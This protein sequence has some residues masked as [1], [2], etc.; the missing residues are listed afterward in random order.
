M[1]LLR[2]PNGAVVDVPDEQVGN[3]VGYEPVEG[4]RAASAIASP[5]SPDRGVLGGVNAAATG[6]LSGITLGGSDYLLK[7]VLNQGQGERLSAEREAHPIAGGAGQIIGAIAPTLAAPGSLLGLSPA[8]LVG[9]ATADTVAAGRALGGAEGVA[10]QLVA[11]GIEG[12]VQNAGMYLSDTALSDRELSAEGLAASLGPGFAFGVA[13]GAAALGIEQGTIAARRLFSRAAGTDKAAMEAEAAWKQTQQA[14]FDANDA[15]AD[16]ARAK[17]AEARAMREQAQIAKQRAKLSVV[18]TE[19][20][21]PQ[22]DATHQAAAVER[23]QVR[24]A[25]KA[26]YEAAPVAPQTPAAPAIDQQTREGLYGLGLTDADIAA[27]KPAELADAIRI[28]HESNAEMAMGHITAG[29]P[30]RVPLN[31]AAEQ[32]LSTAVAEHDAARAE[33]EDVLRR[34][35]PSSIELTTG[36]ATGPAVPIAEW[37]PPGMRGYDPGNVKAPGPPSVVEAATGDVT[38]V[39]KKKLAEG[40]PAEFTVAGKRSALGTPGPHEPPQVSVTSELSPMPVGTS[41]TKPA[42]VD[43]GS[44]AT[45]EDVAAAQKGIGDRL[46]AL[47]AEGKSGSKEYVEL[48][49]QWDEAVA[50]RQELASGKARARIESGA[51]AP[52]TLNEDEFEAFSKSWQKSLAPEAERA[53]QVYTSNGAYS[54]V[55]GPLRAGK[56][57]SGIGRPELRDAVPVLDAGIASAPAPRDMMVHRGVSGTRSTREWNDVAVGDSIVDR[58]F[59][60]TS[61]MPHVGNSYA[62]GMGV[63]K[64]VEL[65]ILVP[66]GYPAA[67]VPSE[68][69]GAEREILLPRNTKYTVTRVVDHDG[70]R[71]VFVT[72]GPAAEGEASVVAAV[73]RRNAKTI[74]ELTLPELEQR[75]MRLDDRRRELDRTEE[76]RKSAEIKSINDDLDRIDQRRKDIKSGKVQEPKPDEPPKAP[77]A[78]APT[79]TPTGLESLLDMQRRAGQATHGAATNTL[80]GQLRSMES[81]LGAG[82]DLKAMGAPARAEYAAAKAEK[83]AAASEHFR[84][85]ANAKNYAGSAM[86][87]EERAAFFA[88]LTRPKTRDAYV[89]QNIGR[90]MKEE[91]SHAK[92]LA[93]V[94]REWAEMAGPT[95]PDAAPATEPQSFASRFDQAFH[96]IDA[97]TGG[98]NYVKVSDLRKALPDMPREEFDKALYDLRKKKIWSMDSPDGR[99]V[100]LS[101]EEIEAGIPEGPIGNSGLQNRLTYVQR[102]EKYEPVAA[103]AAKQSAP[104]VEHI[105]AG[106]TKLKLTT[107]TK[108]LVPGGKPRTTVTLTRTLSDGEEVTAGTAEFLHTSEGLY[109]EH[110]NIEPALQKQG[111]GTKIYDS[112]EKSTGQKI[113]QSE[114]QTPA[115]KAFRAAR[116]E[117]HPLS[118]AKLEQAHEAAVERAAAATSPAEQV[119]AEREVHAIEQQLTAVGKRPG[120]VEDVAAVA[121]AATKYE[122][123]SARLAEALGPDAPPAAQE[124]A[125]A[126]RA[127]EDAA[128]RKTMDRTTRAIDDHVDSQGRPRTVVSESR[129]RS[130]AKMAAGSASTAVPVTPAPAASSRPSWED[131]EAKYGKYAGQPA[132]PPTAAQALEAAKAA[133]GT[134][135]TALQRARLAEM[136]AKAG[137]RQATDT[138]AAAR[139]SR[140]QAPTAAP[141]STSSLGSVL[142][143]IGVAGELGVPGIPHPHDIPVIGPFLGAYLKFRAIKAAAGRFVGRI[144]ATGDARAAALVAKT[145]DKIAHAVDRTLGLVAETAPKVR[146]GMVATTTVLGHRLIDDGE[147]DAPKN[148]NAQQ[149]AAVRI[150]EIANAVSRPDLVTQLVRKEM[151][152]VAD[153]DLIA[154][155]EQ[156]LMARFEALNKVM[157]KA[158]PPN[159]YSKREWVP[160]PAAAYDVAQRLS[161]VHDPTQVFVDPT[162][163]KAQTASAVFPKLL[164]FAQ[165]RL[166]ERIGDAGKPVP[167]EQRLRGSLVFKIPLDDSLQPEHAAILATAHA[168]SPITD[169]A[170]AQA[171]PP[172]PSIAGNS[173]VTAL[174]QTASDRR[175]MR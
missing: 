14:A 45:V 2:S 112:V 64:G 143:T 77:N 25:A 84:A 103:P 22:I 106:G 107:E 17:L 24:D 137:A 89:A 12:S 62:Q 51:G 74:D 96:E 47:S 1:P 7:G 145:K 26:A 159:P 39:G 58:G 115:G 61:A 165:Q 175:A 138:A 52:S 161:V 140:A 111:V 43:F 154:A 16:I 37:G 91:G 65:R 86:A 70:G 151:R 88:N 109:P 156:H 93:K 119:A 139:A 134:A 97:K 38:A 34:L 44:L 168:P 90:A 142:T 174:Y 15:A 13:G 48:S 130:E 95:K 152:G 66:Q 72:A 92:A 63:R 32:E 147:P 11:G 76:G 9:H 67:P 57:L 36:Q 136:E 81:Q 53:M 150:R 166:I 101:K 162:P 50:R 87:D 167:Y 129:K 68:I 157:P 160:S 78:T 46:D 171:Q 4:A 28:V 104:T 94:E 40:T 30:D 41:T 85:Q 141:T 29:T 31:P 133:R 124:A 132:L 8:G 21:A 155:A 127:A 71:V 33:L 170:P 60:S 75:G 56:G 19:Q 126:F 18:E 10:R 80:T 163:A 135:D 173:N 128:E 146:G 120:A 102:G 5:G 122:K 82:A 144:P 3:Y 69:F 113:V 158:P 100:R 117:A 59:G 172:A 148:A 79:E 125:K 110:I 73:N 105:E 131:L 20:A 42:A 149:L 169:A 35:D 116:A 164:E 27:A 99:H 49:R 6:V 118:V 54:H 83:T 153:P 121:Q 98:H 55:N 23:D 114:T 108:P 123:S